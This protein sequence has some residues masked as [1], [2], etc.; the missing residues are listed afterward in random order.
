MAAKYTIKKKKSKH[1]ST[2]KITKSFLWSKSS[3]NK[4]YFKTLSKFLD[5]VKIPNNTGNYIQAR[6]T[7]K[8]KYCKDL[9][10]KDCKLD[11]FHSGNNYVQII[12]GRWNY[13]GNCFK[14]CKNYFSFTINKWSYFMNDTFIYHMLKNNYFH[15]KYK[16]PLDPIFPIRVL[17]SNEYTIP[18][19]KMKEATDFIKQYGYDFIKGKTISDRMIKLITEKYPNL[20]KSLTSSSIISRELCILEAEDLFFYTVREN[21]EQDY[22]PYIFI[23]EK[24]IAYIKN[25]Y[26][27]SNYN[28]EYL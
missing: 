10:I 19:H 26:Q 17:L 20:T 12:L 27:N 9:K 28:F 6:F 14:N 7:R 2:R 3:C 18:K 4:K 15:R 23:S 1:N 24:P 11:N 13:T 21:G 25:K 22:K 16:L 5:K 8:K